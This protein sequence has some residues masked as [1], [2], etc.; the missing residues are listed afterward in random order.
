MIRKIIFLLVVGLSTSGVYGQAD[1]AINPTLSAPAD[2]CE[3]T[4]SQVITMLLVNTSG[5]P[6]SGTLEM[7]YSLNNGPA[8]T[9][10]VTT[11]L[12][13]SGVFTYKSYFMEFDFN[14]TK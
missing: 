13:P 9:L 7:G 11:T 8:V 2:G 6:Y 10:N 5:F 1:L 3:L 12:P 14:S 4:S